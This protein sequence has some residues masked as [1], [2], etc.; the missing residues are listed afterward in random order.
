M[1]GKTKKT[2]LVLTVV[3]LS[4]LTI[5]YYRN[6]CRFSQ[7]DWKNDVNRWTMCTSII[8]TNLIGN[9]T[10]DEAINI[11]GRP[12]FYRGTKTQ[13]KDTTT[14]TLAYL[15]GGRRFLSID[16]ETLCVDIVNDS[17]DSVYVDYN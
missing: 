1:T 16:L 5:Y 3:L 7:K 6:Y 17:V 4:S 9:K 12:S 15:T 10:Y 11:L 2:I 8:N 14:L 13:T